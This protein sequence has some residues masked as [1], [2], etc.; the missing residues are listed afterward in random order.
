[1]TRKHL[2]WFIKGFPCSKELGQ[3]VGLV[4]SL[5][6]ARSHIKTYVAEWPKDIIRFE[7]AHR[8]DERFGSHSKY[9]PKYEMDRQHDRGVGEEG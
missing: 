5:A 7:G 1:M 9:D 2:L 3:K 6:E 4:N 8:A